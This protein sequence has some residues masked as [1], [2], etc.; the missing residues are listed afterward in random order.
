MTIAD[1]YASSMD[2]L[3]TLQCNQ[4]LAEE[5]VAH[6][7]VISHGEPYVSP[8]SY[9]ISDGELLFRTGAGRRLDAIE[10]DPRVCVEVTRYD[11]ESGD[12]HSVIAWGTARVIEESPRT[13]ETIS[14]LLS[15]YRH[16]MGSP[17]S[18]GAGLPMAEAHVVAVRL[19][20]VTGRSSGSF[21]GPRSRPGRL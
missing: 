4:L 21:L 9:V 5:D 3:T 14:M 12:W 8:V 13:S 16:V 19:E 20:T 7:A 10:E 6:I 17:L 1:R 11:G 15:K 2:E 18:F